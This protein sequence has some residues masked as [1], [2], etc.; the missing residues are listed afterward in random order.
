[1]V[2]ACL[3]AL[4]NKDIFVEGAYETLPFIQNLC[5]QWP[6]TALSVSQHRYLNYFNQVLL[7][8][9]TPLSKPLI[10]EKIFIVYEEPEE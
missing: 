6:Y 1:M 10:L 5:S 4:M 2:L 9:F 7:H 3:V 8:D